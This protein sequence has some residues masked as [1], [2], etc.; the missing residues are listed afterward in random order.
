MVMSDGDKPRDAFLLKRG[1]YDAH[2]EKVTPGVPAIL[3]QPPADYP[4]NRL[5]LARWLADKSNPL[6]ARVTVN[7]FWQMYFGTGSGEDR[8]RFR[9]ARRSGR[10]I[11]NCWTGWPRSSS[12]P[13]GI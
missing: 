8:G 9:L 1:A 4:K 7:R 11:R 3:P 12:T 13:A 6:T 10:C 2:G 5:G